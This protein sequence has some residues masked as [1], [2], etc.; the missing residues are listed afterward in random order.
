VA[1]TLNST[2]DPLVVGIGASSQ[3]YGN[4]ISPDVQPNSN[5]D[6]ANE[7][8]QDASKL[9]KRRPGLSAAS[10]SY[11]QGETADRLEQRGGAKETHPLDSPGSVGA[12]LYSPAPKYSSTSFGS[13]MTGGFY[14]P[15][16]QGVAFSSPTS[17]KFG[18]PN[19]QGSPSG[20]SSSQAFTSSPYAGYSSPEYSPYAQSPPRQDPESSDVSS[21]L[22]PPTKKPAAFGRSYSDTSKP[23]SK[24][25]YGSVFNS[26]SGQGTS[27]SRYKGF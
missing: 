17:G 26:S 2:D 4:S 9:D 3:S 18:M 25:S 23:P 14:T 1:G 24:P 5:Y 6:P 27:G 13:P 21:P 22:A 16:S 15:T 20:S 7:G 11:S 10:A 12:N 19:T 8:Q